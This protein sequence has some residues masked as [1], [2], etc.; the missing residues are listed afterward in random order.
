MTQVMMNIG[1]ALFAQSATRR[2]SISF[3]QKAV[4]LAIVGSGFAVIV[5]Y[6]VHF[7]IGG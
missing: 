4:G 1:E 6:G 3:A 7:A 5:A 2:S